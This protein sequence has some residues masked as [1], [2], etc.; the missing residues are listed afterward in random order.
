MTPDEAVERVSAMADARQT[1]WD[2][3]PN[4]QQAIRQVLRELELLSRWIVDHEQ[5]VTGA[6]DHACARC[7]PGGPIVSASF[8]CA[9]HRSQDIQ[10]EL[11]AAEQTG[12]ERKESD[13]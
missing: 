7:I 13:G 8:T 11:R 1:E 2:L 5:Y 10:A 3:S 6:S 4:D 9:R 12:T